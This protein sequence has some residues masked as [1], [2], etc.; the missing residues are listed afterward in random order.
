MNT[1]R[2]SYLRPTMIQNIEVYQGTNQLIII[3]TKQIK[4]KTHSHEFVIFE[5]LY[6]RQHQSPFITEG[7][8][9]NDKVIRPERSASTIV[10]IYLIN[11]I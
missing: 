6:K 4:Q 11:D 1:K 2:N 3:L 10:Y 5:K 7:D 8:K 9:N